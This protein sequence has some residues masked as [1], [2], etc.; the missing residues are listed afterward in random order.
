MAEISTTENHKKPIVGVTKSKKASTHVDLTP[1]V[2]LG[3]LL[4][5]FSYSQQQ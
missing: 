4:I 1:M 2:D 5:P 3:F